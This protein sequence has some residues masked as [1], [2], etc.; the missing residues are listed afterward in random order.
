M[1]HGTVRIILEKVIS[2]PANVNLAD[3]DEAIR[4]EGRGTIRQLDR[5]TDR[6]LYSSQFR[7]AAVEMRVLR[8]L[9]ARCWFRGT[10]ESAQRVLRLLGREISLN[11]LE[12]SRE[13]S[14]TRIPSS[15]PAPV[16]ESSPGTDRWERGWNKLQQTT[17]LFFRYVI[18]ILGLLSFAA[19][20][21]L[22]AWWFITTPRH[23]LNSGNLEIGATVPAA[24]YGL[25]ELQHKATKRA[26]AGTS[27]PL[28]TRETLSSNAF[29]SHF[30]PR[31]A[32]CTACVCRSLGKLAPELLITKSA[33]R[34][35]FKEPL[36]RRWV[37]NTLPGRLRQPLCSLFVQAGVDPL[38]ALGVAF[39][40]EELT[41]AT[42]QSRSRRP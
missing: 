2:S 9:L 32:Q 35:T 39:C 37:V 7:A 20:F 42:S 15:A 25:R 30:W 28:S 34:S 27:A 33:S 11:R 22:V 10:T 31:L 23:L 16:I 12:R 24:P 26:S 6:G 14:L 1:N 13:I 29:P 5:G 4:W 19:L 21:A 41:G 38:L 3:F 18:S 40:P 36:L 8:R 17:L